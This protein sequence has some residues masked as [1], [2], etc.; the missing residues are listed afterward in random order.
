MK[1]YKIKSLMLA[2]VASLGLSGCGD[3]L[4]I[5]PKNFVSEKNY[6]NEKKDIEQSVIGVYTKMQDDAYIRRCII[7]GESRADNVAEGLNCSGQLDIYRTLRE[8]LLTNNQFT[9]WTSFYAVINQCNTIIKRAPEVSEKDPV[10]TQ[11]DVLATIAEVSFL[12]DLTYFYLVRAFKDVPYYTNAIE[13]DEEAL[14][15]APTN[16]DE[17]VKNLIADLE[18][19]VTNALK[20]YPKDTNR[21]FNSNCNR[22]TQNA[23][24]SL[25][26]DLCLWD[27]QYQKCVTYSQK[28]IDAKLAEY[29]EDYAN[30]STSLLSGSN[31][32]MYRW[33]NDTGSG[34]PLYPC[35]SQNTFGSDFNAIFGTGN[36]FESIFEL[37]FTH[38][39]DGD[40]YINNSACAALYG[41]YYLSKADVEANN[42]Q[43]FLA[44]HENVAAVPSASSTTSP[45]DNTQ[46]CRYY[47]GISMGSSGSITT[48]YPAKFVI[49]GT[50]ISPQSGA[51]LPYSSTRTIVA[52]NYSNRNWIF[53]RLTDVMLMQ[54]EALIELAQNDEYKLSTT[55]ENG[56]KVPKV[57]ENG[58]QMF[59]E[60]LGRAF[61]LIYAVNRR[62]IMVNN[63]TST[64]NYA[65]NINSYSS[66]ANFRELCMKERRRELM[67]EGKRWFDMLRRCHREGKVDYIKSNVPAK[68]G[69]STP[70][71]YEALFWPYNKEEVKK[72]TLLD[73]KPYYGN[74]DDEGSF[75]STK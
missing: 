73:Q 68:S 8:N 59:D 23:I 16:G 57:D 13:S 9:D 35:Y 65:L 40:N 70:V 21:N 32:V 18:S 7:W 48:A 10:Y 63:S 55:N 64:S 36:S 41:N 56:E 22:A 43:G 19:V 54:A 44:V 24:Y 66:R 50:S 31:P 46:D 45:F 37:A 2:V 49:T 15:I 29:K 62:S 38:T 4:D 71:N 25:L 28:V 47:A 30:K 39:S 20:A 74:S 27:G 75:S 51:A 6:W 60:D 53:Y 11:S 61:G 33:S 12:R 5:E 17:I 26:A 14:A 3:F 67:F 58:S 34:Y 72:N 69:G 52:G 42:G 1:N